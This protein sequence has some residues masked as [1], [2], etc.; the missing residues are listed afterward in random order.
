M[1]QKD[2][3][4]RNF[5]SIQT[6]NTLRRCIILTPPCESEIIYAEFCWPFKIKRLN[7][8]HLKPKPF[9]MYSFVNSADPVLKAYYLQVTYTQ[10]RIIHTCI[11]TIFIFLT[12][13]MKK[14]LLMIKQ[15]VMIYIPQEMQ[16]ALA[17]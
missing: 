4:Q 17:I 10:Y 16:R 9:I 5:I 2:R 15:E 11:I 7:F 6:L 14:S 12:L 8:P 1:L 3:I 13:M